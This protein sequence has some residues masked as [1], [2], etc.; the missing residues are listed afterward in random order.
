MREARKT[1]HK[2][3][4]VH[5]C[6]KQARHPK[7]SFD[8]ERSRL[9]Y[10]SFFFFSSIM[11]DG[12]SGCFALLVCGTALSVLAVVVTIIGVVP[13]ANQTHALVSLNGRLC[14]TD[15]LVVGHVD[16]A[17]EIR[18]GQ[19]RYLAGLLVDFKTTHGTKIVNA[20]ALAN[21]EPSRAW[22]DAAERWHLYQRHPVGSSLWC[23]Y[24]ADAPREI[25]ST[26]GHIE[27]YGSRV[28][29]GILSTM[30][31]SVLALL[32]AAPVI[33]LGSWVCV[34]SLL[35]AGKWACGKCGRPLSLRAYIDLGS[36]APDAPSGVDPADQEL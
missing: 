9:S 25:V 33:L 35:H 26:S 5:C 15:C 36:D 20:T 18:D 28:T 11:S 13:A 22:L 1:I 17:D 8:L 2:R 12:A 23:A 6:N 19:R 24:D 10:R 21:I 14:G 16:V 3:K 7:P 34:L 29:I 31:M 30:A 27:D 32:A 4:Q